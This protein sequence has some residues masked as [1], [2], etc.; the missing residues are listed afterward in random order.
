MANELVEACC[1]LCYALLDGKQ[2]YAVSV[3]PME[4]RFAQACWEADQLL[5]EPAAVR[6]F[7]N[8][9]DETPRQQ[10]R[11]ELLAEVKLA[12]T[13]NAGAAGNASGPLAG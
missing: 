12:L 1:P 2:P 7:L 3:G 8:W 10:M 6:Y 13:P 11:Q 5:G 9:V 4:E